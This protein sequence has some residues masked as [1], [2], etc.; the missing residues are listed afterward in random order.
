MN[1]SKQFLIL[2]TILGG[3]VLAWIYQRNAHPQSSQPE[4]AVAQMPAQTQ[5]QEPAMSRGAGRVRAP[6][7]GD[8]QGNIGNLKADIPSD[9]R[10]EAPT[11]S[12]RLTQFQLPSQ[13]GGVEAAE[14]AVFNRIGGGV[15]QNIDR[16]VNQ[17]VQPD[18][19]SSQA[20]AETERLTVDGMNV[21][22]VS[23][24]GTYTAGGMSMGGMSVDQPGYGMLAAIVETP[25]GAYYF[26]TVGPESIVD[27]WNAEFRSFIQSMQ[28][29]R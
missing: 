27:Y 8:F 16:W 29:V 15:R 5:S 6:E 18:G 12:M 1:N 14:M 4:T 13:S 22:L 26:K 11:S 10:E 20:V 19:G 7:A 9:W 17:F 2:V 25:E 28:Y 24:T 21:T 23:V 3:L